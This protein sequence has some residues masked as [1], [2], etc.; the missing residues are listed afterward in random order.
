MIKVSNKTP[1]LVVLFITTAVAGLIFS[2]WGDF[3]DRIDNN[4]PPFTM[5]LVVI[6]FAPLECELISFAEC[7]LPFY[8]D[9]STHMLLQLH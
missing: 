9:I 6:V 4:I 7:L 2:P 8:D 3:Y 1:V 5:K